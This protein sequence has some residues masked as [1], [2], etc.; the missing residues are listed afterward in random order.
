MFAAL[1]VTQRMAVRWLLRWSGEIMLIWVGGIRAGKTAGAVLVFVLLTVYH[2][3]GCAYALCGRSAGSVERNMRGY[4]E[5]WCREF[6]VPCRWRPGFVEVGGSRWYVIGAPDEKALLAI[7][8]MTLHGAL[9]DEVGLVPEAFVMQVVSRVSVDEGRVVLTAN[10]MGTRHWLRALV[11]RADELDAVVLD[12]E[13]ADNPGVSERRKAWF[14]SAL[15]GHWRE[16]MVE[17]EWSDPTGLVYPEYTVVPGAGRPATEAGV[18]WGMANPTA[19]VYLAAVGGRFHVVGE[20]RSRAND[21]VGDHARAVRSGL[22]VG[23]RIY[24]DPSAAALRR[25]LIR[26]GSMVTRGD[27]SFEWGVALLASALASGRV[28]LEDGAAPLLERELSTLTWD[29]AAALRGVDRAVRGD[30]HLC[31]G[32]RMWGSRRLRGRMGAVAPLPD[33]VVRVRDRA[34]RLTARVGAPVR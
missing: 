20:Y 11:D 9:V 23:G 15:T 2:G 8:G 3:P 30:D 14:A 28:V 24:I 18:D 10:K 21:A 4:T 5:R 31:D 22:G 34:R 17:N 7:Q 26:A 32:L 12:A 27:N 29:E 6:G 1:T 13:L 19:A 16:R 25:E 33:A